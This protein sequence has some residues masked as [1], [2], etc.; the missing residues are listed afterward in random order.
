MYETLVILCM[1]INY[2]LIKN[3]TMWSYWYGGIL[4][5]EVIW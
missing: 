5:M 4:T 2:V 1:S 3:V